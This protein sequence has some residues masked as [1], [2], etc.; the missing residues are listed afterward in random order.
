MR[1]PQPRRRIHPIEMAPRI[2]PILWKCR[3][4]ISWDRRQRG[5]EKRFQIE[6]PNGMCVEQHG[7]NKDSHDRQSICLFRAEPKFVPGITPGPNVFS[8]QLTSS[9][10]PVV[11]AVK[12]PSDFGSERNRRSVS[13]TRLCTSTG[14]A[15]NLSRIFNSMLSPPCWANKD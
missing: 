13:L 1:S 2:S 5:S 7:P 9:M 3:A 10:S 15:I 6:R 4:V 14:R 12:V 8:N 11:R